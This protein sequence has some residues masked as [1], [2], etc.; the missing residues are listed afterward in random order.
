MRNSGVQPGISENRTCCP[1]ASFEDSGQVISRHIQVRFYKV[2]DS[3]Y[4]RKHTLDLLDEIPQHEGQEN[5]G[6]HI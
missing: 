2:G 6:N 3:E 4:P 1:R 5:C